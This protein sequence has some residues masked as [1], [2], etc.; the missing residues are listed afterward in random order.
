MESLQN[1]MADVQNWVRDVGRLQKANLGR[2]N[3]QIETKSSEVDLVTE[4]DKLSED[5]LLNAI[6]M[7]YPAHSILAEESGERGQDSEYRW[8]IDPLDG[9]TNYAQ[10]LPLFSISIALQYRCETVLG[11]VY[12]PVLDLLFQALKG[13]KAY[14]NDR[15]ISVGMKTNLRECLLCT[16]FPYDQAQTLENNTSYFAYFVPRARGIRRLGSAAYDLANTAAGILDGYWELNLKP[17][18]V[19]AGA[20]LVEEAGGKV[21]FMEDKRGVSLIAGNASVVGQICDGIRSVDA[22]K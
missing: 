17:W 12:V 11:V 21:L 15:R 19:A 5:Y 6:D 18:D 8:I 3:L 14:L 4:I 1:V 7:K 16:G 9:T 20:L 22:K 13:Q 10:G 2:E